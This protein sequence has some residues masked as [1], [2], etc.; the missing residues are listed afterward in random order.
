MTHEPIAIVGIGCRFPGAADA[1]SFW[2]VLRDGVETVGEYPGQRFQYIDRAFSPDA[3]KRGNI[4]TRRGGF[5]PDLQK[6]D[7]EFFGISPREAALLDPQ[8]RLM[9][10]V[11]F[12][13]TEDAGIPLRK[14]Y[15]SRTGVFVG[16]WNSDYERCIFDLS[17]DLDFYTTTGGGRY[18]ASGRLAYFL[19]LRGP[20]LTL[21]TACSSSLVA[22]HLACASLRDGE[23]EMAM[24]GGVNVILR[25]EITLSY[26]SAK[27]L[28]PEGRCKF[29]DAAADGYVRSEGAGIVF[30]KTLS[31][32]VADGDSIYA[33]IRGSAVNND[34]RSS[35]SLIAP[36]CEGQSDM[37]RT[38]LRDAG[39]APQEVAYIEAHG[40]GTLAGDPVEIAAIS[41][42]V[43]NELRTEPCMVGSVKT[44]LGH[45]E[46][47]AGAAGL[48]KVALSL[49][50]G[51]IPA[52]L[53]F[54]EP[55]ARIDWSKNAVAVPTKL[56]PWPVRS[57]AP[58]GGVSGFGITGTNAHVVLQGA[59]VANTQRS[60][61]DGSHIFLLSAHS[62]AALEAR[63]ASWRNRL[64]ADS[65]WPASLADLAY[66]ASAR[67]THHD[68]RLS[69][70]A[71]TRQELLD[72]L[73][74]WIAKQEQ[75]GVRSGKRLAEE[76][77]RAVFVF[78]GQGGQ[79]FGMARTLLR[80]EPV[81]RK[82]LA[83]CDE[84]IKKHTGWSV[85][86][87]LTQMD[88][89]TALTGIDVIQPVLFA[90]M[91]SLAELWRSLGVDPQAVVGHSMG[92]VAAARVCGALS[93]DDA[94][95]VICHRSRLMKRTSGRGLM[96]VAELSLDDAQKF[97][98]G[99]AGRISVGANNSP[100]STVLS[101]D[102]DAIEDALAKLEAREIFCRRIK[103]DVAS[104][105][106]HME[107]FREELARLLKDIRPRES[108]IPF[109]ST[110]SGVIEE[111][112]ALDAQ[113]WTRNLRQPVLFSAAMQSLLADGFDTFV[114]VNS[115]PVLLQAIEDG[116]RH[117]QSDAVAVAS[118]RR[119]K[120]ER[121][122]LLDA[123]GGL[124]ASGF[125]VDF[126]RLYSN[127]NCLR[128]PAYP[129]QRE[130]YWIEENEALATRGQG[131]AAHPNL[132]V[133]VASSVQPG[134]HFWEINL[135]SS[136]A[137]VDSAAL[138]IELAIAAAT[139][140]LGAEAYSLEN[141]EFPSA[142]GK[143]LA[144]QL[145]IEPV[146][147]SRWS[148][149]I[150]AKTDS[151]WSPRC[152]GLICK[153][154][155][156]ANRFSEIEFRER[157]VE[158]QEREPLHEC[159]KFATELIEEREGAGPLRVRKVGS[160]AWHGIAVQGHLVVRAAVDGLP[161]NLQAACRLELPG[162][163][164][165]AEFAGLRFEP[166]AQRDALGCAYQL[167]WVAAENPSVQVGKKKSWILHSPPGPLAYRIG[168]ILNGA[169]DDCVAV[170]SAEELRRTLE[171]GGH[172]WDGVIH[173]AHVAG[174]DIAKN[175]AKQASEIVG[176]VHVLGGAH[177]DSQPP[178]L[179]LLTTGACR[180]CGD[181]EDLA[182]A[183]GSAWGL[184]RVI[185]AEHPEWRC[186]NFDL[187]G[188]PSAEELESLCAWLRAE[189]PE[190]Q[191][192]I[193]G[194]V[195][196]V[197][198]LERNVSASPSAPLQL[199]PS[200]TY[201]ITG[202]LGGVGLNLAR[203]MVAR[204]ARSIALLGR[205][206][207]SDAARKEIQNL[208]FSGAAMQVFSA[209]VADEVQI[210]AVLN[211]IA[212]KMQPLRGVFHLAAVMDS[213]LLADV[214]DEQIDRAM[215]AK[216]GGAWTLHRLTQNLAID[217]F[218]LFS[219]M[220]A[221]IGQPGVASYAAANSSLD[222]LARYRRATGMK[223][224]SI[225]WG[226]WANLGLTKTENARRGVD[227]YAQQGIRALSFDET[228]GA[229]SQLLQQD[230]AG[231]LVAPVQWQKFARS[232]AGDSVPRTFLSLIPG[233]VENLNS[234]P[235]QSSVR[236]SLLAALAGRPRRAFLEGH[237]QEVLAGVLKT[238]ASRLDL[239]KPLGAMGVDSLMALQFVK[240]LAVTTGV[241]LPATAV[242]NYPTLRVLSAELARRMEINLDGDAQA[243]AAPQ[244]SESLASVSADVAE[245]SEDETIQALLQGG[246][247]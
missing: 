4:A 41:S 168:Q 237:L 141:L 240:R 148:L 162:G 91:V 123:L 235:T 94:A 5:L 171:S 136:S 40:T 65:N 191:V 196:F 222:A 233:A 104:H 183:Q 78:P 134:A 55:N 239:L 223:A 180:L 175:A 107:P 15:G 208:E 185:G 29:G 174:T 144:G 170:A 130:R 211:T 64:L 80:D 195:S 147:Q 188:S 184:G 48:I 16:L 178:R 71:G 118:L 215:R 111:G 241:R 76:Y 37:L 228:F 197:A 131:T 205:S 25:P 54:R 31:R 60:G 220:T 81:F 46:S 226:P 105:S 202:G 93:L 17:H 132:G 33:L 56:T 216:V 114:E 88:A 12:E 84:A 194:G 176:L 129:W 126:S 159:L 20:N 34:G 232:Y 102:S 19:D 238:S 67:R 3:V 236:D 146:G 214:N 66:T 201:L 186:A 82:A 57:A 224:I 164:V 43:A 10:E 32:A 103:V 52:S 83:E 142:V 6:F 79:W 113:Y 86:E 182:A 42:V 110:T 167:N 53:H 38:A 51:A 177:C 217:H 231:A 218:V 245:L 28:S 47:A 27:M 225:Q 209:D 73:T 181:G 212:Q 246:G 98:H 58:I 24:A 161:G 192:T 26:S 229:L 166:S 75:S 173:L 119:D 106:A 145:A 187:S 125:P 49:Q 74:G 204:G 122:E 36:S 61:R 156:Q 165:L 163:A 63:A 124:Y 72:R 44:N 247:D 151:G 35:G 90:V 160:L 70:V 7:A 18:A 2:R 140:A 203:W 243:P 100:T 172:I 199:S 179:L 135:R 158:D 143:D 221:V 95:A 8:Q 97:V 101:G 213:T 30:L 13:A 85:T 207:P 206:A 189:N 109:Y 230:I 14:L 99:Y 68:H 149:R 139:E 152:T 92:E 128:L 137:A 242:F 59:P 22:I 9:L 157:A 169:G 234:P 153:G 120:D 210:S 21:D 116:I 121:S 50:N 69:L 200:A 39:V 138:L 227:M 62:P 127:G 133:H 198:R 150:S 190:D 117:A 23:S 45:T 96:A 244:I 1:E 112:T 11:A 154:T 155:G 193:R 87:R 89:D 108:A 115:H 77:R 219:S